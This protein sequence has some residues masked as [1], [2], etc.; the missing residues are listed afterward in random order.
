MS[1]LDDA[2]DMYDVEAGSCG[3]STDVVWVYAGIADGVRGIA[4]CAVWLAYAVCDQFWV[5]IDNVLH[6]Y[7][8]LECGGD[9][10]IFELN[11]VQAV[12]HEL[13]HTAGLSHVVDEDPLCGPPNPAADD[14]MGSDFVAFPTFE[15][16]DYNSHHVAHID[17]WIP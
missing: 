17:A 14:A 10:S 12:R 2:T 3:S 1:H 13:G 7:Y 15:Y 9:G 6:F 8:T 5:R 11:M 16:V 4:N